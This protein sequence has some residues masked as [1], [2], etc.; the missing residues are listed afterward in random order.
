M[1]LA[2]GGCT[3]LP[4][5]RL[6][7]A[8]PVSAKIASEVSASG[9]SGTIDMLTFDIEGF[10]WPA[11]RGRAAQLTRIGEALAPLNGRGQA[12]DVVLVQ[13]MFSPAAVRAIAA[14]GYRYHAWG[15]TR[16][17][18]RRLPVRRRVRGPF[19]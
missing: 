2:L 9:T 14:A 13:E 8:D 16:T 19:R 1:T 11:R 7:T 10:G 12:P 3:R 18:R 15:P 17:Q 4:P 5:M 6:G